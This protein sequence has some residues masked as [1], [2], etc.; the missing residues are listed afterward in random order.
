MAQVCKQNA[1]QDTVWGKTN[2]P[3]QCWLPMKLDECWQVHNPCKS[4]SPMRKNNWFKNV[5][6][7][8]KKW[9]NYWPGIPIK[10]LFLSVL[11]GREV[12]VQIVWVVW[13]TNS[14]NSS[15]NTVS[16]CRSDST[17]RYILHILDHIG[18][19]QGLHDTL[20]GS[21]CQQ[22]LPSLGDTR[23]RSDV[24]RDHGQ[25]GIHHLG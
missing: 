9:N 14:W 15:D 12:C 3:T 19:P 11:I 2:D 16:G 24:Q 8:L 1:G 17:Q 7:P 6:I 5:N 4:R 23:H 10:E 13:L 25:D 18:F 20:V 21:Q 22:L